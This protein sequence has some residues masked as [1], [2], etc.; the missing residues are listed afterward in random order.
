ML[1]FLL[2]SDWLQVLFYA[3]SGVGCQSGSCWTSKKWTKKLMKKGFQRLFHLT[4]P[5][6][7]TSQSKYMQ[8]QSMTQVSKKPHLFP[9]VKRFK[10]TIPITHLITLDH[11]SEEIYTRHI[12]SVC[13]PGRRLPIGILQVPISKGWEGH[14]RT[15]RLDEWVQRLRGCEDG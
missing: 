10:W 15:K 2:W 6:I 5:I 11:L 13:S 8:Q 12:F 3:Q 14:I 9:V 4:W 7:V 1:A